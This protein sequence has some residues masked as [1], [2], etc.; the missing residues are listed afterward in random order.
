MMGWEQWDDAEVVAFWE[1][2]FFIVF[3]W[4]DFF[5]VGRWYV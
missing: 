4:M 5:G 3:L 1:V 2:D